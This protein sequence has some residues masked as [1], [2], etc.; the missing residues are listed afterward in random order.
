MKLFTFIV[1]AVML[2]AT[3]A[4]AAEVPTSRGDKA[5]VFM[6]NG[7]CYLSAEEYADYGIGLRYYIADGTALRVGVQFGKE[8]FKDED[9][10]D[11]YRDS[12]YGVSAVYEKHMA[13]PCS[14]VSPY[15]GLGAGYSSF[16]DKYE[17]DVGDT[18]TTSGTGFEGFGLMGFEWGFTDCL[19]LGGEYKLGFESW[20]QKS[21]SDIGGVTATYNEYSGTLMGFSAASV[22]LSVYF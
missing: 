11:E 22:Y 3:T 8:M 9:W 5:M 13:A 6:F 1:L 17:D 21:E 19:T 15:W 20:S 2:V 10:D 12:V 4:L 16:S 7:L 18:W 14:S